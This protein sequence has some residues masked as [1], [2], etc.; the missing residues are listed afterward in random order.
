MLAEQAG[1]QE[2]KEVARFNALALMRKGVLLIALIMAV[3]AALLAGVSMTGSHP[4]SDI[5]RFLDDADALVGL[6]PERPPTSDRGTECTRWHRSPQGAW[7]LV[8][9]TNAGCR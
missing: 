5:A 9:G 1:R 2:I 7:M 3:L 6:L 4:A 8:T